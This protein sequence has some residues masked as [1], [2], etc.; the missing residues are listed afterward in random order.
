MVT[1]QV[2]VRN[3]LTN[4]IPQGVFTK[5]DHPL[6]TTLLDAPHKPLRIGIQVGRSGRQSHRFDAGIGQQLQKISRVEWIAIM[7]E[8]VLSLEES[9][10][11]IGQVAG[12]LSHPQSIRLAR[13]S[14]DLN[15]SRG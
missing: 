14:S 3:K 12:N 9:V 6:Q 2:I 15:A 7:N 1:F 13:D 10:H 11:T 4:G 5:E 8:I